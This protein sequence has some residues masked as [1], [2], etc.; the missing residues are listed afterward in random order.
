MSNKA[1]KAYLY[2]AGGAYFSAVTI[3]VLLLGCLLYSLATEANRFLMIGIAEVPFV[4]ALVSLVHVSFIESNMMVLSGNTLFFYGMDKAEFMPYTQEGFDYLL[5]THQA[6]FNRTDTLDLAPKYNFARK[7]VYIICTVFILLGIITSC[8]NFHVL[9][10]MHSCKFLLISA[11]L[12]V[13]ILL[14][15]N[16][17]CYR[18]SMRYFWGKFHKSIAYALLRENTNRIVKECVKEQ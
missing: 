1:N 9:Y 18:A 10:H 2:P 13:D 3:A 8:Y 16:R 6:L 7:M 11:L 4:C 5:K 12:S 14:L 17:L 15:V